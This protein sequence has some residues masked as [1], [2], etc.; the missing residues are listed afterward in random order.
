MWLTKQLMD[1]IDFH[2]TVKLQTFFEI[3]SFVSSRQKFL[4]ELS[5]QGVFVPLV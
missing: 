2:S 1:P 3:S 4:G 5:L